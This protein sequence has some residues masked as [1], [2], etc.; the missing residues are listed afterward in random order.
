MNIKHQAHNV[1]LE[2]ME[3][4]EFYGTEVPWIKNPMKAEVQEIKIKGK[5]DV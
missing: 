4:T 2:A 3:L 1:N 5:L